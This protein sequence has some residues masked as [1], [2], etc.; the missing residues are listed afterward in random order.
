ML[1]ALNKAITS[2]KESL[3]QHIGLSLEKYRALWKKCLQMVNKWK[4]IIEMVTFGCDGKQF[5]EDK[6]VEYTY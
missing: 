6:V 3:L 2:E 5:I 4:L 1:L